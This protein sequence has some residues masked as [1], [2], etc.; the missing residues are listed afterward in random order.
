MS[1]FSYRWLF[2]SPWVGLLLAVSS[3][4][5]P[6]WPNKPIHFIVPFAAG[7]A[8]DLMGRAAAEGASKALG[9]TVIVDNR[10]GAGGS[11]GL[12]WWPRVRP[13]A[14]PF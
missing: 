8:N 5:Q 13:M 6:A 9:Q 10:P 11:L 1:F 3:T 7:G 2:C 12:P 14:I 4:A